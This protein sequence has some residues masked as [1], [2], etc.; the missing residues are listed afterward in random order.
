MQT[1]EWNLSKRLLRCTFVLL[2]GYSVVIGLVLVSGAMS[3]LS[4]VFLTSPNLLSVIRQVSVIGL[5][6]IGETFVVLTGEIDLSVG[7]LVALSGVV[8]AMAQKAGLGLVPSIVLPLAVGGLTGA[9]IGV[10]VAKGK[11]PSFVVTLGV[12]GVARGIALVLTN[13]FPISGFGENYKWIGG[14]EVF[15]IPV[16]MI[17]LL[18]LTVV[19][20]VVLQQTP[21]GRN[22]YALGGSRKA[23]FYSGINVDRELVKVFVLSGTF[24]ALGGIVLTARLDAAETVAGLGYELSA[25]AAVVIGGASLSGGVGSVYGTLLGTLFIGVIANGLTLLAVSSYWQQVVQGAIIVLAVLLDQLRKRIPRGV[26]R[27]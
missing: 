24:A 10:I 2:D 7:S 18:I 11:V 3:F 17:L 1:Q 13:G 5:L 20:A 25:I 8:A 6:A 9:I 12:M 26:S 4:P 22:L 14:G 15:S 21:F 23:A 27:T 16:P 19:A